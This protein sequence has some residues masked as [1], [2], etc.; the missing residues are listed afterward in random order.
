MLYKRHLV[1]TYVGAISYH[2]LQIFEGLDPNPSN[3]L[4]I[5]FHHHYCMI[6]KKYRF[7]LI[8]IPCSIIAMNHKI[9]T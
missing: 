5:F 4:P 2:N 3:F 6:S 7:Y 9:T 8:K 1:E